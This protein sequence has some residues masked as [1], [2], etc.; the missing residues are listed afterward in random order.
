VAYQ[1]FAWVINI[2]DV[3]S[4]SPKQHRNL[5]NNYQVVPAQRIYVVIKF[6]TQLVHENER[7][8]TI[9]LNSEIFSTKYKDAVDWLQ[10]ELQKNSQS[11]N[12]NERESSGSYGELVRSSSAEDVCHAGLQ[13]LS[14]FETETSSTDTSESSVRHEPAHSSD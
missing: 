5:S 11:S 7:A 4:S 3:S 14:E 1:G 6:V 2:S 9:I 13:V 10:E 12:S 8:K